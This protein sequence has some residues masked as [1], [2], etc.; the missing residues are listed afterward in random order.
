MEELIQIAK[1]DGNLNSE[2]NAEISKIIMSEA[3]S[4]KS[5]PRNF[6]S[7]SYIDEDMQKELYKVDFYRVENYKKRLANKNTSNLISPYSSPKFKKENFLGNFHKINNMVN[8]FDHSEYFPMIKDHNLKR[9]NF[10]KHSEETI[11]FK[12]LLEGRDNKKKKSGNK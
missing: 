12:H 5:N 4:I 11:R 8:P 9:D 6:R 7:N 1:L 3:N 2:Y 10:T